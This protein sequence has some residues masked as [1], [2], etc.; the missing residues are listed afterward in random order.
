MGPFVILAERVGWALRARA[1][2]FATAPV[3]RWVLINTRCH[4]NQK[5][6]RVG[7]IVI[8]AERVGFEPTKGY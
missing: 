8:L 2:S 5:R 3:E 6:A 1:G 7:P 4:K